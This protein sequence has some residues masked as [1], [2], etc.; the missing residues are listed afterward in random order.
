MASDRFDKQIAFL[1]AI[2]KSKEVIRETY[3]AD[4]SRLENAAEHAWHAAVM[5]IVFAEY[6]PKADLK[7][8]LMMMLTHDLVEVFAGDTYC[9]DE[10]GNATK[11]QREMEAAQRLYGLLP[12][13]QKEMFFSLWREF[14]EGQSEE[15]KFCA[16][17]DRVQPT[18]LNDAAGWISWKEH[19]VK[20]AQVEQRNAITFAGPAEIAAYMR[21][22][23]EAAHQSGVLK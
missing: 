19:E 23:I 11:A 20:K 13:D 7:K 16:I 9:Y 17:L 15:A 5:A 4:K 10:A 22:I 8:T 2:D 14:E 6:F 12:E 1:L 21:G 3:L 18:M